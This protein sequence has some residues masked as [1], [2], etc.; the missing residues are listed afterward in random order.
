MLAIAL[1]RWRDR[2]RS[3]TPRAPTC[4]LRIARDVTCLPRTA[5]RARLRG[6]ANAHSTRASSATTLP[7]VV[8]SQEVKVVGSKSK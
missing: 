3:S 6:A 4:G 5:H 1:L 2:R 8:A 7:I